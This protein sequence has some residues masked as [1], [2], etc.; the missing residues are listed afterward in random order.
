MNDTYVSVRLDHSFK[1]TALYSLFHNIYP[2]NYKFDGE[3]HDFWE[4]LYVDQGSLE[5]TADTEKLIVHNGEAVFHRPMEFHALKTLGIEN[6]SAIICSFSCDHPLMKFFEKRTAKLNKTESILLHHILG[7]RSSIFSNEMIPFHSEALPQESIPNE[8]LQAVSSGLEALLL[9]IYTREQGYSVPEI[10]SSGETPG[11]YHDITQRIISYLLENIESN[12]TLEQIA[13]SVGYSIPHMTK[14][15]R[16]D[17]NQG[18][19]SYFLK[20]KFN[21]AKQLILEDELSLTQISEKL[22]FCTPTYFSHVFKKYIGIT[23]A[24]YKQENISKK[25]S[26][27]KD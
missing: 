6:A 12:V 20:I 16:S 27:D 7:Y 9:S 8:I 18:I 15:F 19:I 2:K 11:T 26:E 24:Q 17:M 1:I 3:T 4:L 22:G 5:V 10:G 13:K 25:K 14:I 23:P 21:E